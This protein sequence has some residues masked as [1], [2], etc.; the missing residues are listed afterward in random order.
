MDL[1]KYKNIFAQES[2]KYLEDLDPLLI[3]VEKD[4]SDRELWKQIHGKIHSIKGMARALSMESISSLCHLME[5]WCKQFQQGSCKAGKAD[6]Q[7]LFEGLDVLALLVGSWGVDASPEQKKQR[8]DLM[9]RFEKEPSQDRPQVA[10][11]LENISV[12]SPKGIE[13][14]RIAYSVIEELLGHSQEI[15]LLEKSLP[16]LS[17]ELISSGL[18]NWIDHCNSML[19]GLYLRL[20][21]LRLA[22]V[23]DF[24]KLFDKTIRDL[25][26]KH[27]KEAKIEIVG[28]ELL[29]DI[30]LMNR[31]KEPFMHL[32]RNF[33]AH[34]IEE[35]E[36]RSKAGKSKEGKIFLEA[37]RKDNKLLLKMEDDG[38]GI[39]Q[40]AI[41]RFLKEK[42][43]MKEGEISR[44]SE[45]ELLKVIFLPGFTTAREATTLAGRGIGMDVVMRT[46]ENL[47]GSI[48]VV[49]EPYKY[50]RFIMQFPLFLSVINAFIF[51]VGPY[52][53]S[54]P[55]T[56]IE[57]VESVCSNATTEKR[58]SLVPLKDFL[59]MEQ[60]ADD[61]PSHI[62]RLKNS[63]DETVSNCDSA[64][65]RFAVDSI[66]GN[67]PL[68]TM[69]VGELLAKT[70][71]FA[72]V[73]MM[74]T[75][76]ISMLLD[77]E[78]LQKLLQKKHPVS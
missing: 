74:E 52:T 71:I 16:M 33:I 57:A 9:A 56:R 63:A 45:S 5:A 30:A 51:T 64:G 65:M 72:G 17:E 67:T 70:K 78:K 41:R 47:G 24:A 34:G 43:S 19:K 31:L 73:G 38:R 6:V 42:K 8:E 3:S 36:E 21:M 69:P 40:H 13:H 11:G 77:V 53:L 29:V 1:T 27:G 14:V 75:G 35:P 32:M 39:D 49:S 50:T 25:A 60:N 44:L 55:T 20:A 46:I 66:I 15:I 26:R 22:P 61:R 10:M 7:S 4:C 48:E 23:A 18:K 62:I 54:I 76:E 12:H 59:C 68:T 2:R 58:A 37:E 28:G